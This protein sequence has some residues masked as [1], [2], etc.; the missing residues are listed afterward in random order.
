LWGQE[1]VKVH[2]GDETVNPARESEFDNGVF[3]QVCFFCI[4]FSVYI[5][6]LRI[7]GSMVASTNGT[8]G[9]KKQNGSA[10]EAP[11]NRADEVK[12]V[13]CELWIHPQDT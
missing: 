6:I 7:F 13:S 10:K 5:S 11:L 3:R 8:N 2:D 4:V 9:V 1:A 12:D